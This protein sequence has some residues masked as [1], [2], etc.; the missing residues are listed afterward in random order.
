M[1]KDAVII[2]DFFGVICSEIAPFWL[3]RYFSKEEAK[4][5]KQEI[6]SKADIGSITQEEMFV[7]LSDKTGVSPRQIEDSWMEL[8]SINSQVVEIIKRYRKTNP[9]ALLTN[10]PSKFVRKIINDFSLEGLFELIIVSSEERKAKPNIDIFELT[11]KKLCVDPVNAIMIDDNI[12]N[13]NTADCLGITTIHFSSAEQLDIDLSN[14]F[15]N[16]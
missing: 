13:L 8:V 5:V 2:F 9:V 10:A 7:M 12:D 4:Q 3:E 11:L 16:I 1:T 15:N 6:V 14:I